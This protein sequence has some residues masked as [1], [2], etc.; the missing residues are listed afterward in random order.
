MI[1][2]PKCSFSEYYGSAASISKIVHYLNV[3][4][5]EGEFPF[6]KTGRKRSDFD[7]ARNMKQLGLIDLRED[8]YFLTPRGQ[9]ILI[10][11]LAVDS[12]HLWKNK[13]IKFCI[14]KALA[15]FDWQC[16]TS[17]L[18]YSQVLKEKASKLKEL[19]CPSLSEG[20]FKN[21]W[22]RLHL[23]LAKE[24][25]LLRYYLRKYA[26]HLSEGENAEVSHERAS[27]EINPY[28]KNFIGDSYFGV[29]IN[30]SY[31][32]SKKIV[33]KVL[34]IS[35]KIYGHFY[36]NEEIGNIE[37]VKSLLLA[38]ALKCNK[39]IS[40]PILSRVLLE[41]FLEKEIPVYRVLSDMQ[42]S[43]RGIFRWIENNL[44]YYPDFN[45]YLALRKFS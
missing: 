6:Q 21:H 11:E 40:E 20:N 44:E 4:R 30:A 28:F 45:L 14:L 13:L 7:Y 10:V 2:I 27:C 38:N 23:K 34:P 42:I 36:G 29:R 25:D 18:W 15:D 9:S 35:L 8:S 32:A 37:P 3:L 26:E 39:F 33:Q 16:I 41:I 22:L 5:N 12:R 43:G 24:T 19:F 1:E 31:N 17:L